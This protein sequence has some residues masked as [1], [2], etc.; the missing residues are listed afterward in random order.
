M[1]VANTKW[2]LIVGQQLYRCDPETSKVPQDNHK[3]KK[4]KLYSLNIIKQHNS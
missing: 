2:D 4:Y 3:L 1:F